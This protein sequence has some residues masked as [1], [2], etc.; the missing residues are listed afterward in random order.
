MATHEA[1]SY[2]HQ[3][4]APG[5]PPIGARALTCTPGAA[6]IFWGRIAH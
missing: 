2:R 6:T 3:K 1:L 4:H 5:Q